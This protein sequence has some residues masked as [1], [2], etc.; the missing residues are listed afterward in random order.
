V[1]FTELHNRAGLLRKRGRNAINAADRLKRG[2]LLG[3]VFLEQ[4][5]IR[6][7][8]VEQRLNGAH[9]AVRRLSRPAPA[10]PCSPR[11]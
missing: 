2:G 7:V 3:E 6:Y 4:H 10:K 9:R 8:S 11:G 5:V 1:T